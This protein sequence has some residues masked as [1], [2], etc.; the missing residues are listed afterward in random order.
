MAYH[1][2]NA[3]PPQQ[4]NLTIDSFKNGVWTLVDESRLPPDAAKESVNLIQTQDGRYSTRPGT[5]TYGADFGATI[6]GADYYRKSDGSTELLAIAGGTCYRSTDG[7][8]KTAISGATFTAGIQC[9][10]KQINSRM[11]IVNG[12]DPLTYYDGSTLIQYTTISQP[13]TP[14][15]SLAGITATGSVKAYYQVVAINDVGF[16]LPSTET[17]TLVSKTRD[18]WS[19]STDSV[20]LTWTAPSTGADKVKRYEIYYSDSSGGEVYLDSVD[21]SVLSYKD[22]GTAQPNG[23]ITA[24]VDN[25]TVG[26]VFKDLELSDNHLWGIDATNKY[27]VWA[28]GTG[29]E[30]GYFS[31]FYGG[32]YVDLEKG[33]QEYP[34][35][36]K[37]F[38]DGKGNAMATVF[39]AAPDG[40]GSTWQIDL[41]STTIGDVSF[42]IPVTSKVVGGLGTT[43]ARSVIEVGNSIFFANKNGV[44]S[45]GSQPSLL[46]V[47]A[48][49]E[50]SANIR[51]TWRGLTGSAFAGI[52]AFFTDAKVYISVPAGSATQ[53]NQTMVFDTE[54]RNWNPKA[55][56]VGVKQFL[57]YTDSSGLT[58]VLGIP[59]TGHYLWEFS[60]NI[61]GDLG[62][63]FSTSYLSGLMPVDKDRTK[64]AKIVEVIVELYQPQG[65]I[66]IEVLG[67]TKQGGFASLVSRT[68]QDSVSDSGMDTENYGD[69]AWDDPVEAPSAYASSSVKKRIRVG[70]KLNNVQIRITTNTINTHYTL[71]GYQIKGYLVPTKYP[72]NWNN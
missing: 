24:P 69:L 59:Y 9:T 11:Y 29:K 36:V 7:G 64:F 66:S 41:Q 51:P 5:A 70:Q 46:N 71:L 48:T 31:A 18:Q 8:A 14:T 67:T 19:S 10:L 47:L 37:H 25:T 53:N 21:F 60:D 45:L 32:V 27:R 40:T 38:R 16:S 68:I 6:D 15:F 63:P 17:S 35:K 43:A 28:S 61:Q 26:P 56:S 4:L 42:D 13:G 30:M 1:P 72:S 12:T 33:G 62:T 44:Y 39:T 34:V 58:H 3:K 55:Y 50:L 65:S 52:C 54:R 23:F 22:N 2:I 20:T 49:N 57:Q